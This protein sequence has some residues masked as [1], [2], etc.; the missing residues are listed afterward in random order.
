MG[1]KPPQKAKRDMNESD[2]VAIFE[3]NGISVY[4]MDNPADLLLGYSLRS[5][6][7]EVKNGPKAPF[8]GSQMAFKATWRGDYHVVRTNADADALVKFIKA[9][10][11]GL[12][13]VPLIG[14]IS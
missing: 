14:S 10:A 11:N 8:T 5:Y 9:D 7:V 13:L 2:V 1:F 12:A 4:R 3:A 6:L